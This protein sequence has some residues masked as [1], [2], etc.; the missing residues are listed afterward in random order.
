MVGATTHLAQMSKA[1]KEG[2]IS[3]QPK[4]PLP[5]TVQQAKADDSEHIIYDVTTAKLA[6]EHLLK[7]LMLIE[8]SPV[9][10][11][12]L[13]HALLRTAETS[14]VSAALHSTLHAIAILLN[15]MERDV[16]ESELVEAVTSK[17]QGKL[18]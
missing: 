2:S 15:Q 18:E 3:S 10:V 14:Q 16:S 6:H 9:A 4:M 13:Q 11:E 17:V 1:R 5:G 12:A 7:N 8:D